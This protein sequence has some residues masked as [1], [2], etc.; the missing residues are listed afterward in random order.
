MIKT[1]VATR[2][3]GVLSVS[4]IALILTD[5]SAFA[6]SRMLEEVVITAQK[7]EQ[8]LQDVGVAVTAF[9]GSQ[10]D[11]LGYT[12][13]TDIV[14]MT[15]GMQLVSPNGG[16]S[17]FF[18]IRGVTQNDFTD[19]QES[20]VATYIDDAYVSQMSAGNFLLFDMDRVEVLR[21]PQ[22]TLF[23][24]NATGGLVHF[25]TKKPSQEFD[26]YAKAAYGS[27]NEKN[28]EGAVGGALSDQVAVRV[29]GAYNRHDGVIENR[30]G[31][32]INNG[33]NY[34]GRLQALIEPTDNFSALLSLRG[35]E[36]DTRAGAYQHRSSFVNAQGLGEFV[37]DDVDY[38]GTCAGCDLFGYKD[39][40]GD[41]HAG[42]YD[43][44]GSN[45]IKTWGATANLEWNRD[46]LTVTS[47]TDYF[48]L[49]KDYIEDS[50]ASPAAFLQFYLK[51]DIQQFSQ[52][53]RA[54]YTGN[55]YR[56]VG[57]LYYLEIDGD[58]VNGIEIPV[59][60]ITLDN[61]YALDTR[62][63]SLFTQAEYDIGSDFTII[64]GFRWTED[65]KTIDYV[66]NLLSYPDNAQL[67]ELTRFN[68]AVSG[69][70]KVDKGNWSGKIELDW[71]PR[72]GML[73]YASWN[74][75]IKG[76]GLNAPLDISG[77]LDP[78]TGEL[79]AG[80]MAFD[81]E[82]IDAYELGMKTELANGLVRLN[83][84]LF[85]Y[86]YNDYQAFNFQGLTTF[87]VNTDAEIYGLDL[88]LIASPM[89]G[90]DVMLGASIIHARAFDVPL[91][92]GPA[93]RDI[94]LSPDVNLNGMVRYSWPAFG[95]TMA[96]QGDFKYLSDHH[97]SI[98]NAPVTRQD[99][100]LVA[101]ARVSYTTADERWE[102]AGYV[103]NLTDKEY[104]VIGFDVSS[105]G[106]TERFPG[107]P[108]WWGASVAFRL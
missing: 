106:L 98:S 75:G 22:G 78:I 99:S 67:L 43:F 24:R 31:R 107:D 54:L 61:P 33:D 81:D 44:V 69:L 42:D 104:D 63:W 77:L 29:S 10:M 84:A 95:G 49:E 15:P 39:T 2:A 51:S 82:V 18:T 101:N 56:V 80:R 89:A 53:L 91:P 108:I 74:R 11:A 103:K 14:N 26:A 38:Y 70:A 27:Y 3:T 4:A 6:Q 87:I 19:H 34:A 59:D 83:S 13:S 76:G 8:N 30:I 32:D 1:G 37:P 97:F 100:Y 96:L 48:E 60:G 73:V 71:R 90:L 55:D 46:N 93:D 57:G 20:P 72:D 47:I 45:E 23:G 40:D 102:F 58:Y 94:A 41:P 86:D 17:N 85:Y 28:L 105:S 92:S 88:E 65:K 9:T 35:A 79:Q 25:I 12:S 68:T 16:S 66:S 36:S 21:G 50:D 64:G 62:S 5:T 7:R 52:E